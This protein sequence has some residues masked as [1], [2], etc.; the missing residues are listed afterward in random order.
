M[1]M[2]ELLQQAM[3]RAKSLAPDLQ[4]EIARVVLSLVGDD[5]VRVTLTPEEDAAIV[6]SM[7]AADRGEFA[8]E[9]QI[10]AVWTKYGL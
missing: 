1:D 9:A 2:T 7:E 4:D 10:H 5:D 3:D 6:R 8:T